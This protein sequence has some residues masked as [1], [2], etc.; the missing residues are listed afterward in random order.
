MLPPTDPL[1]VESE[2][3]APPA[4]IELI[5]VSRTFDSSP[6]VH[7]LRHVDLRVERGEYVGVVGPSGSGKSTFLNVVGLL[8][9]PTGGSY[10]LDGDDAAGL[11]D[12]ER[13]GL[14]ATQIGF[15]F[16]SFHLL[17]QRSA[18]ENV[19]FGA[20]YQ[21][22]PRRRRRQR[23]LEALDRVLARVAG[24]PL[25]RFFEAEH[26]AHGVDVRLEAKVACI[27][28]RDGAAIGVRLIDGEILACEMVIVG[29]GIEPAVAP[30]LAAGAEGDNGVLVDAFC[31]TS[32]PD[33]FAIGDCAAH[34]NA[35]AGGAVIRLE[36]VQN[37]SDQANV[38]A[39]TITG[40]PQP[41]HAVPWFWSNQYDLKL[42]TVGLSAGHDV[43]IVRGDP[44][45]RSFSLIYCKDGRIV[46]LD[47]VNATR[48]YVQGRALIG[49]RVPTDHA[50]LASPAIPLKETA[51][52]L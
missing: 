8:D 7:A 10:L 22:V 42:Q 40:D 29:I 20:L 25:S 4:L 23:A 43:V 18:L 33:V 46:A 9:R 26:R 19:M 6:P 16:Q 45:L 34:A 41:Y 31:R 49:L 48:D 3:A 5:D 36:S 52:R 12:R 2:S 37:A 35:F 1:P 39:R 27:E 50:D 30:L 44:A 51:A 24:E 21:G 47:C 28:E 11:S 14:R 38:V 13:A 32:L 17:P 15:I